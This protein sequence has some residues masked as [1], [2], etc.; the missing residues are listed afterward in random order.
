MQG[1]AGQAILRCIQRLGD[2]VALVYGLTAADEL[3]LL[4]VVAL[5]LEEPVSP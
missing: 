5:G 1:D 2:V 4:Q 3:G